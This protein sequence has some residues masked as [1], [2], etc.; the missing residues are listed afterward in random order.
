MLY[1]LPTI[2]IV[3]DIQTNLNVLE[4]VL[5]LNHYNTFTALDGTTALKL[6]TEK[7]P[8]LILLD[9]MMPDMTGFEVC[10]QLK[11]SPETQSI[12]IIFLTSKNDPED[13]VEGFKLGAVDYIP[14]PFNSAELLSRIR[15]H[16]ELKKLQTRL[17]QAVADRT[18]E[19]YETLDEL[20]S[21]H[22]KLQEAY[23]E[24]IKRLARAADYRDN[25]TGMHISRMSHYTNILAKAAG[26]DDEQC[27]QLYRSSAMHDVGKIGIPDAILLK[28]GKLD[29]AEF[30]IMKTHTVIGGKLLSDIDS[31]LCHL[32]E[33]IAMTHHEKW[34]GKGYPEGLSGEDI[35]I[36]GRIVA[37][38]DVFDALTSDRPYKKAW[39]VE[40]AI[41][42]LIQEKGEH[43]DPK[44]VDIFIE[45]LPKILEVKEKYGEHH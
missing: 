12:P 20:K 9:V 24:I 42:L 18:K 32:A 21:T 3:D 15:T 45:N 35:P 40:D 34:N 29:K 7:K 10:D 44:L 16:T 17:E 14:K 22:Y 43:F 8:D 11:R 26:L 1:S 33:K 27:H 28:P 19:L 39:S 13:I 2:L 31:D 38:A 4:R 6:V 37:I 30:D 5:Q 41:Q 36:E 25:E 23:F